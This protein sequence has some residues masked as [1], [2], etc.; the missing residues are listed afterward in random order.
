MQGTVLIIDGISTNRI[1]LKVQLSASYYR[2]VQASDLAGIEATIRLSRPDLI[3]AAMKLPDGSAPALQERLTRSPDL[4]DIP[5]LAITA[6]NDRASRLLALKSG[7]QDVLSRPVD[8]VILLARVRSLIRTQ[9]SREDI[10]LRADASQ[11]VGFAEAATGFETQ[12]HVALIARD[13]ATAMRWQRQLAPTTRQRLTAH[14]LTD[15]PGLLSRPAPDGFIFEVTA[16]GDG[17]EARLISELRARS[18][19][20]DTAVLAVVD[21]PDTQR[22]ADL[23]DRGA[24]DV[25]ETGF[26]AEEL[27]LRLNAQ[28]TRRVRAS[29]LRDQVRDGLRAAVTDPMTGLYNRRYAMPRL[30]QIAREA[31]AAGTEFALLIADLDHFKTI[32]DTYGHPAGDAVLIEAAARMRN[33]LRP[34]DIL[35]R[36]GGEEF[37][38][39]LPN[40]GETRAGQMAEALC[41]MIRDRGIWVPGVDQAIQATISIG[42]VMGPN[43]KLPY[44]EGDGDADG[45]V[46]AADMALYEAKHCGR[47]KVRMLSRA[48]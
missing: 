36:I 20:R 28:I 43:L 32:N 17:E 38:I 40:T 31:E 42:A 6:Q 16:N 2:V 47:N 4:A 24:D 44:A 39:I 5:V 33:Q 25:L 21:P 26:D 13:A 35:A 34:K 30:T 14:C 29:R 3:I 22:S 11:A 15:I 27:G 10:G 45:L 37:M 8:D 48:A 7:I 9:G 41:H 23:L 1:M 18:A 12:P 19:T 46:R